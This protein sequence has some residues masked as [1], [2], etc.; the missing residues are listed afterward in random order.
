MGYNT[1]LGVDIPDEA[2]FEPVEVKLA[3]TEVA[4]GRAQRALDHLGLDIKVP[5]ERI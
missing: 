4:I 1:C 2:V 3:Q 5:H